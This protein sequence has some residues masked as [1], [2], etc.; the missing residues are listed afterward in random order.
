MR[1]LADESEGVLGS[2]HVQRGKVKHRRSSLTI[3]YPEE[4][5]DESCSSSTKNHCGKIL[6]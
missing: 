4:V 2:I 5:G 6:T 1:F 3:H